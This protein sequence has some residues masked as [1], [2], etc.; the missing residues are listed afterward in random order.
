MN[1][2]AGYAVVVGSLCFSLLA[3]CSAA[4]AGKGS[5]AHGNNNNGQ[6]G[7]SSSINPVGASGGALAV[8]PGQGQGN[9]PDARMP[10]CTTS[11]ADFPAAPI[12]DGVDASVAAQTHS[13][14]R[15]V[16]ATWN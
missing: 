16:P 6:A 3:G 15:T 13:R 4:G 2:T 8:D 1:N 11:C 7:S 14:I 9:A 5:S 10:L 12:F